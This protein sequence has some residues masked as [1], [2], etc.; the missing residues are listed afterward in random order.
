[1]EATNT[2]IEE[3][4]AQLAA[5]ETPV[6]ETP[7]LERLVD[8]LEAIAQRLTRTDLPTTPAKSAKILDPPL[9]IDGKDPTFES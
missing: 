9:L 2:E 8:V 7:T 5:K 4:R 3:L 1:M 6:P